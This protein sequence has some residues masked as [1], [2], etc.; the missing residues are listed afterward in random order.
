M[1]IYLDELNLAKLFEVRHQGTR[2]GIERA[3][4]L[5]IPRQINVHASICEDHSAI[6]RK[7]IVYQRKPLVSF[8]IT[9]PLE[10][11]IEHSVYN[12]L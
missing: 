9:G 8:D 10:E 5:A 4:R 7:T 12:V 2:D 3:V 11:L 6:A 1:I